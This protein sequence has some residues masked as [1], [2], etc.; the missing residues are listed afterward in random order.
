MNTNTR[1]RWP[2]DQPVVTQ[3]TRERRGAE[4]YLTRSDQETEERRTS[5]LEMERTE[6]R[7]HILIV[8]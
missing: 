4:I 5:P 3:S 7:R 1:Y 8:A 6:E 2:N